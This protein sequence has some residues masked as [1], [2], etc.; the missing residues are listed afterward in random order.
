MPKRIIWEIPGPDHQRPVPAFS[1]LLADGHVT[2][3]D[4]GQVAI[5]GPLLKVFN[6]LNAELRLLAQDKHGTSEHRYPTLIPASAVERSGYLDSFPQ[7]VMFVSWLRAN[8]G[9]YDNFRQSKANGTEL[10]G[11]AASL[12]GSAERCLPPT[13]CFHTYH[14]F[15]GRRL[16]LG[17]TAAVSACG[18][19]FRFENRY[20]HGLERL[21]DF[22]M[23]EC[24]FL[25]D[26][27]FVR[28]HRDTLMDEVR[29][30]ISRLGLHAYCQVA[31]DPFFLGAEPGS[32]ALQVA[33]E[34]KYELRIPVDGDRTM[35]VASFNYADDH[36]GERF[37]IRFQD[38]TPVKTACV[39]F[40]LERL[41]YAF[42]CQ[43]G[44]QESAWPREVAESRA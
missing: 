5:S 28:H 23:R 44:V 43:H 12:F 3:C 15:A 20:A 32:A 10:A 7:F 8:L 31:N 9:N 21:W 39:G 22:T 6:Y 35:A 34:S 4:V 41:A 18:K 25:G 26:R 33:A 19:T 40:G 38:G 16:A 13:M 37:D 27:Q 29:G 42:L 11:L 1:Q 2:Q 24:I 17:Q 30:L 14:Q 36:F